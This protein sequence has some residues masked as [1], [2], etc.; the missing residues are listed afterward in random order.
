MTGV[1]DVRVCVT[2]VRDVRVC[3]TAVRDVRVCVTSVRCVGLLPVM[4]CF[5]SV[6]S[7]RERGV[8]PSLSA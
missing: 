8:S 1:R 5:S 7:A 2:G 4:F 6:F 3:V